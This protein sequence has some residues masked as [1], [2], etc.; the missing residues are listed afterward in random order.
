M[1]SLYSQHI[2]IVHNIIVWYTANDFNLSDEDLTQIF[3]EN[4]PIT[5]AENL[6]SIHTVDYDRSEE[7]RYLQ[8]ARTVDYDRSEERRDLQCA[9]L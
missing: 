1:L 9:T 4:T 5:M 2:F 3:S 7:R 6:H 8:C